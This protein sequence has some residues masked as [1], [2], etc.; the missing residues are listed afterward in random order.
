RMAQAVEQYT[1]LDED[2]WTFDRVFDHLTVTLGYSEER[3]LH[4]MERERLAGRLVVQVH[5]VVDGKPQ[6]DPEYLPPNKKHKLVRDLGWVHPLALKWGA[7][8]CT[9]YRQRVLDLWPPR[10]PAFQQQSEDRA[11]PDPIKVEADR[12]ATAQCLP[13]TAAPPPRAAKGPVRGEID[14]FGDADRALFPEIER[15][16]ES[17][18]LTSTEAV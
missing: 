10:L 3:A 17:R 7:D 16:M 13:M 4:E 6:G 18:C 11:G 9:V 15:L 12:L 2:R 8:R 1:P 5:K 14:R